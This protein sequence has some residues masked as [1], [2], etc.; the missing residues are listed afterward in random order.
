[1]NDI[2]LSES[3]KQQ[4]QYRIKSYTMVVLL[5]AIIIGFLLAV[6]RFG[7]DFF[8]I[9]IF[10]VIMLIPV[11]LLLRNKLV[12]ILPTIISDNLLEIDHTEEKQYDVKFNP[13]RYT[14]QVGMYIM[15]VILLIGSLFFLK[16]SKDGLKDD[17][18]GKK[19]IY[20]ILGALVCTTIA[21]VILLEIDYV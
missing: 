2:K 17:K 19:I 3:I 12:N 5:I 6:G 10:F 20:K 15:I 13:S 9:L 16:K 8:A 1:M 18:E 11:I 21:G 7:P 4:P 14:K